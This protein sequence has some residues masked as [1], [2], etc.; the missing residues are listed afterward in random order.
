MAGRHAPSKSAPSEGAP[1]NGGAAPSA[2][3]Y[4]IIPLSPPP[5]GVNLAAKECWDF[6]KMPDLKA[7]LEGADCGDLAAGDLAAWGAELE[8]C[9]S[10]INLLVNKVG[11][12]LTHMPHTVQE[13]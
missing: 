12:D 1:S 7:L 4:T 6:L 11:V 3:T 13:T 2:P 8:R 5:P 9:Q 10:I